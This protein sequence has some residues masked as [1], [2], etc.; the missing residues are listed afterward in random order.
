MEK[1]SAS[2][3]EWPTSAFRPLQCQNMLSSKHT[4]FILY[5]LYGSQSLLLFSLPNTNCSLKQAHPHNVRK[6]QQV[7]CDV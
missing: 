7:L 3:R 5:T 4:S 6:N 1:N 2:I